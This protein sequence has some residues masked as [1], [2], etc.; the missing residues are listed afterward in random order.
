MKHIKLPV[1]QEEATPEKY[2]DRISKTRFVSA[3]RPTPCTECPA[4]DMYLD[5]CESLSK[6]PD[7]II[8]KCLERWDCH[9]AGGFRCRGASNEI[10][11]LKEVRV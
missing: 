11:R 3:T 2:W 4:K 10:Q 5:M 8:E 6:Q 7:E 1:N 9:C